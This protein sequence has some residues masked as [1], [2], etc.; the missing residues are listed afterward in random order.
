M[1]EKAPYPTRVKK[2]HS[3]VM[4]HLGFDAIVE[5][6]WPGP[7]LSSR[8]GCLPERGYFFESALSL[9]TVASTGLPN[10]G[11]SWMGEA[12]APVEARPLLLLQQVRI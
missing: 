9:A 4:T 5:L 10:E 3:V 7:D 2:L 6:G 8:L 12:G 11:F 1:L